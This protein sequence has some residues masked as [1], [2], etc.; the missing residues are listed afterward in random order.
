[1]KKYSIPNWRYF[2]WNRILGLIY[3]KF[4]VAVSGRSMTSHHT[5]HHHQNHHTTTNLLVCGGEFGETQHHQ[6]TTTAPPLISCRSAVAVSGR[7][8]RPWTSSRRT[9][10]PWSWSLPSN[11]NRCSRWRWPCWKSYKVWRHR[12]ICSC[13]DDNISY[14]IKYGRGNILS[15]QVVKLL[16]V[17]WMYEI[18]VFLTGFEIGL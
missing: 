13:L 15:L 18:H 17:L 2:F 3:S 4:S 5:H 14:S 12:D 7:S 1:M 9:R 6:T 11:Q 16:W 8:T 10:W